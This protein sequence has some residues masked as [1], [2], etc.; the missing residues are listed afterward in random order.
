MALTTG[1]ILAIIGLIVIILIIIGVIIYF[2]FFSTT[3]APIT[4]QLAMTTPDTT[5]E[6]LA[7]D[8]FIKSTSS[9][10]GAILRDSGGGYMHIKPEGHATTEHPKTLVSYDVNNG[11]LFVTDL[12]KHVS[13]ELKSFSGILIPDNTSDH[14]FQVYQKDNKV[15]IVDRD[16]IPIRTSHLYEPA[17]FEVLRPL[18][19]NA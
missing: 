16:G 5:R 8:G 10:N 19:F 7:R 1:Q 18:H 12:E 9:F 4:N 14:I 13:G 11:K 2:V 17:I 3:T 15:V 6:N